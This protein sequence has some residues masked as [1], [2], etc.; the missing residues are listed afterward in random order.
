MYAIR[1]YYE[2]KSID[3]GWLRRAGV[4]RPGTW[5]TSKEHSGGGVLIDLGSHITDICLMLINDSTTLKSTKLTTSKY[6]K[7]EATSAAQWFLGNY[8][9]DFQVNVED[10]A[11]A[12]LEYGANV[13]VDIKLSWSCP[14]QGDCTYFIIK[15]T[16][17][18]IKLKTL[19]GFSTDRLWK[20]DQLI[21]IDNNN[22]SVI[23]YLDRGV[24]NTRNA[25]Y[26]MAEYFVKAVNG[27]NMDFLNHEDALKS[28]RL[29]EQLYEND[30]ITSYSIHYTKLY[31]PFIIWLSILLRQ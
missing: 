8:S 28:V 14:I 6:Q 9:N 23:E 27:H 5:F 31:E 10:T 22:K 29:I 18:S 11:Y 19:F 12:R 30:V 24:N 2:I 20:E 3:A 13:F 25:F 7:D 16:K 26:N 1:S 4:P 15:G 21:R 17:S